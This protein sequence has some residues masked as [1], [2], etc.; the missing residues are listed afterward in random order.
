MKP[1]LAITMGDPAGI[2]PEIIVKALNNKETYEK[3][4]PL[5]TGDASVMEWAVRQLGT[6]QKINIIHSVGEALFEF[7]TI[8]VYDLQCV[9]MTVFEPGVVSPQC[10]NAAFVSIIKAIELAMADEVDGTVTAPLNK[11]ALHKGGHNFDGHTEIYAHFTGT[12]K[13][14]MLLADKFMR[15]IHVSTHVSLREACDRVKKDRIIE[16]TELINDACR[17]FGFEN[18]HIG[19]AGLNPHASDNGLFGWEE[20]KEI[21]PAV[22]ELKARGYNVDGPVPPDTLFAKAR[23]GKYDGCVAMYHDQGHIPFKV[24]G[25]SWNKETGKMD[26]AQGVNITLGL[27]IIRVSVDHGTAFD[28]AGKGIASEEA[29]LLSIDYATRMA[30]NRRKNK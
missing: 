25:F 28:V 27:P 14:A 15:V 7:G 12:K 17:Q 22:N 29:M 8:D 1:I 3:C 30:V 21:I 5:V 6:E 4:R 11:E 10:G 23:C 9:D 24:V 2:G 19:I 13:Y 16:V 20:E 18:P 26:S